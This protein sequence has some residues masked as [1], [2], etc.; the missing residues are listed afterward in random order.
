MDM[1]ARYALPLLSAGQA[2]KEEFH[3]EALQRLD[4]CVAPCVA[5]AGTATPPGSPVVGDCFIVGAGATGVWAGKSGSLALYG[6]GGWRFIA[7]REGLRVWVAGSGVDALYRGGAWE[8][9]TVRG[10]QLSVGGTKVVGA[11]QAA[12]ADPTGGSVV[13]VQGRSAVAAMLAAL[14][15][16]G[17]IAS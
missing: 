5:G 8:Y 17:L 9:G 4:A 14:R 11:Q 3:N 1:T 13:D 6:D 16:H 2:Q 15:A 7:A 12:I 10:S